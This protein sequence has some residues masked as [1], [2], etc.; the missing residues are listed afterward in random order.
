M[1]TDPFGWSSNTTAP[2]V[3][4]V[5][6]QA[7]PPA[8]EFASVN[9][10]QHHTCGVKRDG[11]VVC[12][13]NQA[14][15]LTAPPAADATRLGGH[16]PAAWSKFLYDRNSY[17]LRAHWANEVNAVY[18]GRLVGLPRLVVIPSCSSSTRLV[19]RNL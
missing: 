16:K 3:V 15:G 5:Y 4:E 12:W 11:S 1:N 17:P 2:F 6:G 8:G 19:V 7:R 13:G 9:A 14:R 18:R 10:G